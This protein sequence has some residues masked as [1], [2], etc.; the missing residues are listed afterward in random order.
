MANS[1]DSDQTGSN[2]I[3]VQ[4]V[5]TD[6]SEYLDLLCYLATGW[7]SFVFISL[8]Q[9]I[10]SKKKENS[11]YQ[12]ELRD[13][14]YDIWFKDICRGQVFN[15]PK[16]LFMDLNWLDFDLLNSANSRQFYFKFYLYLF[17]AETRAWHF[18][19]IVRSF[20][21]NVKPFFWKSCLSSANFC[22]SIQ[23]LVTVTL[24]GTKYWQRTSICEITS[25]WELL[26]VIRLC[27]Y[28][29]NIKKASYIV[30][31]NGQDLEKI[32]FP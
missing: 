31:H 5:C 2:L 9:L 11:G 30:I 19:Q 18:M 17:L 16:T 10:I 20:A 21:W 14:D 24:N 27:I 8:F 15:G 28:L 13:L 6:F 4:T 32:L 22:I 12:R 7:N 26:C 29:L 25:A 3:L 23:R 1:V